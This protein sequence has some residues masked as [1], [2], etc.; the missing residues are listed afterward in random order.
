MVID[1]GSTAR[2]KFDSS[3]KIAETLLFALSMRACEARQ[4]NPLL[5]DEHALWLVEQID[6]DFS[7]FSFSPAD[8]V[9]TIMRVCR[10]DILA[11]DFLSRRPD[12]SVVNIG[13]GLDS[14][15]DRV[16]NGL[17][18]WYDLDLPEVIALRRQ[19]IPP[20]DR[21]SLVGCSVLE[22]GWIDMVDNRPGAAFLFLAEGVFPYFTT[23]Q[24]RQLFLLLATN[25]PG[26]ELVCDAMSPLIVR[27]NNLQL[28]A[29]HLKARLQWGIKH[30][31]E[32][33]DWGK[34][35][36]LLSEW[37]YFDKPEPRLG[38]AQLM[39]YLPFF[40]KGVGVFHYQL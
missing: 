38:A 9:F 22:P 20:A 1:P 4:P 29:S 30:S 3:H 11:Q 31:R 10:F 28:L 14:R 21:N 12:S 15:F 27:L 32:P 7:R 34:S 40:A 23:D 16:D 6:F 17:V 25:F 2:I 18:R 26:C 35:I 39:R 37:F 13:C 36:R 8:R 5:Y 19:L 33:E 24:V